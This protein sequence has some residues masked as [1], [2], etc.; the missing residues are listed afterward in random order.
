M[1]GSNKPTVMI[2]TT[3]A[4]DGY[5]YKCRITD[6]TGNVVYTEPATM[7]VLSFTSNP[8]ET[9]AAT[10]STITFSVTATVDSGFTYQWQYSPDGGKNWTNT[11]MTGCYTDTLTVQATK[12]RNG[13]MYR[14]VLTGSKNSKIESKAATLHVS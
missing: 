6:V 3:T 12:A 9:F 14:C 4:R 2:Q 5:Q 13:Y 8:K 10:G 1:E 11:T 7:R